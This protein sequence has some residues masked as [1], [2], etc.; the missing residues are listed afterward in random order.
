MGKKSTESIR[1]DDKPDSGKP[2]GG[3]GWVILA[4]AFVI[5]FFFKSH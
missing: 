3:Y 1:K 5:F 2:D 4:V